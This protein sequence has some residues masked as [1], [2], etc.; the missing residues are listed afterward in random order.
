PDLLKEGD[1]GGIIVGMQPKVVYHTLDR[2]EEE[3]TG[4]H[5]EA[6]YRFQLNEYISL[7]PA[8]FIITDPEHTDENDTIVV[9]TFRTTF[10]F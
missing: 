8:V 5:I 3:K 10:R 7:I 6:L 4:I 9:T 2:L 1:L